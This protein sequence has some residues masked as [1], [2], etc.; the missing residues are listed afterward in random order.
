VLR[1]V[2]AASFQADSV[3][4]VDG[5]RAATKTWSKSAG[6]VD[7]NRRKWLVSVVDEAKGAGWPE[8]KTMDGNYAASL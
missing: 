4:Y 7:R 1:A 8:T 2:A 3:Y 5:V 6:D